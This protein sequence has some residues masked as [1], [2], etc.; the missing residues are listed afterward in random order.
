VASQWAAGRLRRRRRGR[1]GDAWTAVAKVRVH[2]QTGGEH[3][4][5]VPRHEP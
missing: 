4:R 1:G 2:V 5:C 3:S